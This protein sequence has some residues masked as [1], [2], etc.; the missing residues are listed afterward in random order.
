[1]I[2]GS[3]IKSVNWHITN[4]CNYSCNFCFAQNL[5]KNEVSF[6]EGLLI[7]NK[8]SE[9]GI[10]KINFAGGEPL[11]HPRLPE[12]CE[13]AKSLGMTVAITT[14]GSRLNREMIRCLAENV[15]WI[16]LSVDSCLDTVEAA[17]GRGRGEH[18]TNALNSA[19]LIHEAGI[20]LKVNTTVT[21]LT[22]QENMKPLIR[23]M[24]PDRWKVMQMLVVDGENDTSSVGLEVTNAQFRE[25]AERHRSICLGPGVYPIFETAEDLEGSYFMITPDGQVMSNK[26]R[27]IQC[28]NLDYVLENG[29]DNIVDSKKYLDR[30]GIYNW[31]GLSVIG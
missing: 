7:L 4:R 23:M 5:G 22:W 8:L 21:S 11:L 25:F 28:Y 16:A 6:E 12:Y 17:M 18:V 13:K 1:M 24:E 19:F 9:A 15:D 20:H 27:K 14:N 31:N 2:P 10:K 3:I 29:I 26:G 30:G